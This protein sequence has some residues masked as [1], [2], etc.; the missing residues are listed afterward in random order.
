M[1][2]NENIIEIRN[3]SKI[4]TGQNY[5][6]RALDGVSL[7]IVQGEFIAIMGPSGSGKSTLLNMIGCMDE[8]TNGTYNLYGNEITAMKLSQINKVR[9]E[10]IGFV[11]QHFALMEYYTA[12]ENIE[13]PL[14]TRNIS[15]R[16][17]KELVL[18]QMKRLH[19]EELVNQRPSKMSG[20]QRQRVAIARA[21]VA[22]ASVILADE[23]TGAL[24]QKTGN[25]VMDI[26]TEINNEGKTVILVTHDENVA[27][28]AHRIIHICDGKITSDVT[29][30]RDIE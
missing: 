10:Y 4:Y 29:A 9:K 14:L 11:F 13:V 23:P 5:E 25:E 15:R 16:K 21:I 12:Y 2:K 27:K 28:K 18:S 7:D 1:K 17:R 8:A 26:L 20:G 6:T 22:D 19:I 24:D 3:V 30:D